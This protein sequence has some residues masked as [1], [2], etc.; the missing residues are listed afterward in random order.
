MAAR[1]DHSLKGAFCCSNEKVEKPFAR[2]HLPGASASHRLQELAACHL[3]CASNTFLPSF[4]LLATTMKQF[5]K[6]VCVGPQGSG[7]MSPPPWPLQG[8]FTQAKE[9][10]A[11]STESLKNRQTSRRGIRYG[12]PLT[13]LSANGMISL[14]LKQHF[15]LKF[16]SAKE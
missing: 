15:F 3:L 6:R 16:S 8:L 12:V 9:H 1:V 7:L 5:V 2:S 11:C 14:K 4:F 10:A 13:E